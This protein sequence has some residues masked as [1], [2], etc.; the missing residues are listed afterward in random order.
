[1]SDRTAP[2]DNESSTSMP[3]HSSSLSRGVLGPTQLRPPAE[4]GNGEPLL[5]TFDPCRIPRQGRAS[6]QLPPLSEVPGGLCPWALRR[7][8]C[9]RRREPAGGQRPP[10]SI[11]LSK[12][13]FPALRPG[14]A[15]TRF[16]RRQPLD[17]VKSRSQ[18]ASLRFHP[19]LSHPRQQHTSSL[20]PPTVRLLD[21]RVTG[22]SPRTN[23]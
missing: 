3:P 4:S 15:K 11:P 1:M 8:E 7:T 22:R 19:L 21:S 9:A 23:P 12:M 14:A 18:R 16:I 5:T 17:A 10:V 2:L 20:E 6:D 13:S